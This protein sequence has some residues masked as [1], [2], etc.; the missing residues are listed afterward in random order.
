METLTTK[1]LTLRYG[2][3]PHQKAQFIGNL[4]DIFEKISGK[5]LSYNNLLDIDAAMKLSK[6]ITDGHFAILKHNNACGISTGDDSLDCWKSALSCDPVSAFGGI[7]ITNFDINEIVAGEI[8]KLFFEVLLAPS[9]SKEALQVLTKKENRIILKINSFEFT[10]KQ[11]RTCLNGVLEQDLDTQVEQVDSF[12]Y[13]TAK[14]PNTQEIK[15][16]ILANKIAKHS[17]SNTIILVKSGQLLG[18]GVGMTSRI[19]ALKLAISKSK[20]FGF[21]LAGSS[22]ASDAFFPFPDCVEIAADAGITAIIQPGGSIKDNLSI[23]MCNSKGISMVLTGVRHF[24]H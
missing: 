9:Y 1:E 20:E 24:K 14:A 8:N 4:D 5:E 23:D 3:N 12:T 18:S 16:L 2:E 10:E 15:D 21:D 11:V 13:V 7:I 6:D 19:D 22:M 17:K